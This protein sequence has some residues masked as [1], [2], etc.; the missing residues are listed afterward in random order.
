MRDVYPAFSIRVNLWL[1]KNQAGSHTEIE[2][3]LK[4][5]QEHGYIKTVSRVHK[6]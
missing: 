2:M 3:L 6:L 4:E 1:K 5:R